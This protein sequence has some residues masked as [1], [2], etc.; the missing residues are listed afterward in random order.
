MK[1]ILKKKKKVILEQ[2]DIYIQKQKQK[3]QNLT[4]I[5]YHLENILTLTDLNDKVKPMELLEEYIREKSQ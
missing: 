5:L 4:V 2:L 1:R 3:T